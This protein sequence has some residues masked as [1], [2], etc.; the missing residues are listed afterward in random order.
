MSLDTLLWY[1]LLCTN[2]YQASLPSFYCANENILFRS[3][4]MPNGMEITCSTEHF[5]Y[6]QEITHW[7]LNVV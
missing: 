6:G 2:V 4:S 3:R 5:C 7:R 1:V